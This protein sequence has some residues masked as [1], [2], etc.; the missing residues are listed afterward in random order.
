MW[1]VLKQAWSAIPSTATSNRALIAYCLTIIA[2]TVIAFRVKRNQNL[3]GSLE[4]LPEKDRF[5]ALQA[6]MGAVRLREGLSPADWLRSRTQL[7]YFVAF[8]VLCALV[9]GLFLIAA[10]APAKSASVGKEIQ[11]A[12]QSATQQSQDSALEDIDIG[13][14][15]EFINSKLGPPK[16]ISPNGSVSLAFYSLPNY[17][18]S[19]VFVENQVYKY[20]VTSRNANFH[21]ELRK[22]GIENKLGLVSFSDLGDSTYP[23]YFN[24]SSKDVQYAERVLWSM[25]NAARGSNLDLCYSGVG[26]DYDTESPT[27]GLMGMP[28]FSDIEQEIQKRADSMDSNEAG[29]SEA[30]KALRKL[31]PN[32]YAV[33]GGNAM[34]DIP[35][36]VVEKTEDPFRNDSC[37]GYYDLP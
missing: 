22:V 3:L 32:S 13:A 25:S 2:W 1:E 30:L 11:S 15:S 34:A 6:E 29:M 18:L 17:Y 10:Y 21:P 16:T 27:A 35:D 37:L 33:L 24:I 5:I 19:A 23:R 9:L 7:Y 26:V 8:I 36:D 4:K 31:K 20:L 12:L 14:T 28:G